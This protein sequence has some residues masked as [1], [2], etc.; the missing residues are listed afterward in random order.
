MLNEV[1]TEFDAI[2]EKHGVY[3]VETIGDSYSK[4]P[5]C[6]YGD[7][8]RITCLDLLP[9]S[10][11]LHSPSDTNGFCILVC[12]SGCR[13]CSYPLQRGGSGCQCGQVRTRRAGQ[14]DAVPVVARFHAPDPSRD[15]LRASGGGDCRDNDAKVLLLW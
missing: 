1:Y 14:D 8:A 10:T 11:S 9:P 3:K 15:E 5:T 4:T 12:R 6:P 2:A 13:W 7:A